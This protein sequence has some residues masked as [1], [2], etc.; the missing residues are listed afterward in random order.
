MIRT[1]HPCQASHGAPAFR[2]GGQAEEGPPREGHADHLAGERI[3]VSFCCSCCCIRCWRMSFCRIQNAFRDGPPTSFHM[4]VSS[5]SVLSRLFV[6][7]N[8]FVVQA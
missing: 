4:S 7:L 8:V 3:Q 6:V 5:L 2:G 1:G